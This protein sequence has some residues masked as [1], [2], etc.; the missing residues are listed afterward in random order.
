MPKTFS[1]V[2]FCWFY[3]SQTN[4]KDVDTIGKSDRRRSKL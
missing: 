1:K 4:I 2:C 3:Y